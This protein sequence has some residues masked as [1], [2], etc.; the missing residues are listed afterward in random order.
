MLNNY[1]LFNFTWV[2]IFLKMVLFTYVLKIN[3]FSIE[4][5][6]VFAI[7]ISLVI[8]YL[9]RKKEGFQTS[10]FCTDS[11]LVAFAT[12]TKTAASRQAANTR[13]KIVTGKPGAEAVVAG[14]K[15]FCVYS[16]SKINNS[17]YSSP[18]SPICRIMLG[19]TQNAN[20]P[21]RANRITNTEYRYNC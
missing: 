10:G 16:C 12:A 6:L 4:T 9:F 13:C 3:G 20:D 1:N 8:D 18:D 17:W 7:G 19:P 5:S 2:T 14:G 21:I 11:Q 15:T